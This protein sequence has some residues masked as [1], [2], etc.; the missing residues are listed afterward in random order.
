VAVNDDN[1]RR[2]DLT[3][4][5]QPQRELAQALRSALRESEQLDYVASA[6]LRAARARALEAGQGRDRR[7]LLASGGLTAAAI[8]AALL[9]TTLRPHATRP[10]DS[11]LFE[12]AEAQQADA[13]DVLTD[14]NDPDFYEEL[15]LYR[16]LA[17][18]PP[19][20]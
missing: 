10:A 9:M 12:T 15:D 6:K 3:E 1:D 17:S 5:D 19:S 2:E 14:D 20:V 13:L 8:F 7:W 11:A 16:W 4:L 18:E